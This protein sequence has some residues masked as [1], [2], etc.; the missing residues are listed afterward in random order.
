[1]ATGPKSAPGPLPL[2]EPPPPGSQT[3]SRREVKA[4]NRGP[5]LDPS[6]LFLLFWAQGSQ[7][8]VSPASGGVEAL[9]PVGC[10]EL[11]SVLTPHPGVSPPLSPDP[12][13]LIIWLQTL[14]SAQ[15]ADPPV[16]HW[17]LEQLKA[18][19]GGVA[20]HP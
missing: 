18:G 6:W 12:S 20:A 19:G 11:V 8:R 14:A 5:A 15:A 9:C 10:L 2:S 4:G 7:N 16:T 17:R 3:S 1:M 13:H